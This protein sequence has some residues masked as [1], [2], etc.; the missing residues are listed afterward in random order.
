MSFYVKGA[1]QTKWANTYSVKKYRRD[2]CLRL[3]KEY[4]KTRPDLINN[5]SELRGKILGCWCHPD[6][7]H[8]DILAEILTESP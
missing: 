6:K 3:Y 7:C 8:G 2:E 4:I 1:T 5:I